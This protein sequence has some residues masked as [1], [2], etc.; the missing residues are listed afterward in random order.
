LAI[1]H[2]VTQATIETQETRIT[3]M[4]KGI[5]NASRLHQAQSSAGGRR[6]YAVMVT[7]TYA[8]KQGSLWDYNH[9]SAFM[10]NLRTYACR[11]FGHKYKLRYVWVL[12]N[13]QQG[14][15]HYHVLLWLPRGHTLP[16]PDKRG[17]WSHGSTRIERVKRA[18]GYIAKYA[19]KGGEGFP[20]GAR[21]HACG[22]LE[23]HQRNER[24]W[25][26][27]PSWIRATWSAQQEPRP[28]RGGGWHSRI[29]GEWLPSP[30]EVISRQGKMITIRKK[31]QVQQE[32]QH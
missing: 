5:L 28:R 14:V 19:S 13:T 6:H 21:M 16:K 12:E 32:Q 17:W 25:W 26:A 7:L 24:I 8:W 9:I 18:V 15:P 31:V 2:Q 10:K 23:R 11:H 4:R 29:T 3:R 27:S 22:G 1:H 30:W 20:R